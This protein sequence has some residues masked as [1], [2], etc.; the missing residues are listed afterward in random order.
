MAGCAD[1]GHAQALLD[2]K[3]LSELRSGSCFGEMAFLA[4]CNKVLRKQGCNEQLAARVCDVRA[5]DTVRLVELTVRDFLMVVEPEC[6]ENADLLG[7][8]L[9][10]EM[11][12]GKNQVCAPCAERPPSNTHINT[13][14]TRTNSGQPEEELRFK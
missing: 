13:Y 3:V 14:L 12:A 2:G 7:A 5:V 1:V 4:S 10:L 8:L 6:Q 9:E 11:L